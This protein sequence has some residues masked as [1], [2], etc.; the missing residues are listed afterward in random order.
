VDGK[1]GGDPRYDIYYDKGQQQS[2]YRQLNPSGQLPAPVKAVPALPPAGVKR[3]RI[4][5][6][7]TVINGQ[8]VSE[9]NAPKAGAQLIFVS[10][11]RQAPEKKT[12]ANAS[13]RFEVELAQ[14]D[15]LIYV[16]NADGQQ[17]FHSR[18]D[19]A[20]LQTTPIV[21]VSR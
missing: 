6:N 12:T 14:G 21:L 13:G 11:R 19:V 10:A 8:V 4:A 7:G 5:Q 20:A 1:T 3:E 16:R 17:N 2:Q 15:W 18:I 9:S